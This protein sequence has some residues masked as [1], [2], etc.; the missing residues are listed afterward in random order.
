MRKFLFFLVSLLIGVTLLIWIGKTVGWQE[1]KTALLVFT[2][3][4][5]L[6]IF[7]LT[8]LIM[9]VGNWKWQEILKGG[10]SNVPFFDLLKVYLASFSIRFLAP[11]VLAAAELFQGYAL[12]KRSS[13]SWSKAMASVI[14]D[15][16]SEWTVN[17]VVIFLGALFFLSRI[18]LPPFRLLIIFGGVFLFFSGGITYFYLKTLKRESMAKVFGKIFNHRLNDQ[19]LEVEREIF[20]FFRLKKIEMWK[21]FGLSFLR[22][23]IMLIRT[24]LLIIFLGKNIGIL[25]SL[26]ILGFT[27][28]AIAIPIPAALGSHEAI[29]TFAFNSMG[30]SL[31]AATAFTMIIRGVELLIVLFGAV[32]LSR[33]GIIL[34][35]KALFKGNGNK[36]NFLDLNNQP[37]K[38]LIK[39]SV[40]KKL[41]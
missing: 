14:I 38:D 25:S 34:F 23:G 2:G 32:I 7:I 27:Y 1:I 16:V 21:A 11:I 28:L 19:P 12:K 15:R 24:W 26:S 10:G 6:V 4:Q 20:D 13:L 29:Q 33:L 22:A 39:T 8:I 9:I 31:G 35:K 5:G 37:K 36:N 30:L 17:L 40:V 41:I 18:G 3:W